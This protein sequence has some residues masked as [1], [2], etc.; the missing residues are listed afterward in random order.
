[1]TEYK[2]HTDIILFCLIEVNTS[3]CI[4]LFKE[5]IVDRSICGTKIEDNIVVVA[6]CNPAGRRSLSSNTSRECDLGKH[7]AS[8]HY[9]VRELPSTLSALKWQYGALNAEQEKEFILRRMEMMGSSIPKFIQ[10]ELTELVAQSQEAIR[11]LAADQIEKELQNHPQ[12]GCK[13]L[14]KEAVARARSAVSLRDI[15][16]VFSLFCFFVSEFPLTAGIEDEHYYNSMY[17]TIAIVYYLQLDQE[18]RNL[19]ADMILLNAIATHD[20]LKIIDKTMTEI[21]L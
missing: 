9:Q 4:G 13:E 3:S 21:A 12:N 15:Q 14:R 18:S 19:F 5:I 10:A 8:G 11:F 2:W 6:A 16:R 20:F 7:W 17:L 1:M